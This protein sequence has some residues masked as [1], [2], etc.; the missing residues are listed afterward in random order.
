MNRSTL[1][2]I[3]KGLPLVFGFLL[4]L[5]LFNPLGGIYR[6]VFHWM[7]EACVSVFGFFAS[8]PWQSWFSLVGIL[9]LV[10]MYLDRKAIFRKLRSKKAAQVMAGWGFWISTNWGIDNVLYP[11]VIAWQGLVSGGIIMTAS[12]VVF[13]GA[14]L[15]AYERQKSRNGIDW[16]GMDSVRELKEN[17][18]KRIEK[19]ERREPSHRTISVLIRIILFVPKNI[20]GIAVRMIEKGKIFAFISLSILA[21]S[22]VVTAY[23]RGGVSGRLTQ[24]DWMI[25]LSS[26]IFSNAY[27]SLR[28][29]GVVLIIRYVWEFVW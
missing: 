20:F 18:T 26:T 23:F 25:F 8:I 16:L 28:S 19:W 29:F 13:N 7:V 2:F 11:A 24:K 22:F 6:S 14:Y 12:M 5:V 10:R 3:G 17:G 1:I 4:L 15:L 27:W 9:L 21:D